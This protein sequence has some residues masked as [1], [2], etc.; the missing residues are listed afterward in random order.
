MHTAIDAFPIHIPEADLTDLADRLARTRW[1]DAETVNDTSQ[2]PQLARIR[3][4]VE[5]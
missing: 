5:R 3:A 4:L 1:P 2:G